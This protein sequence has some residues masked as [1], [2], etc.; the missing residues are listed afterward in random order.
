METE[1]FSKTVVFTYKSTRRNCPE[2]HDRHIHHVDRG[3]LNLWSPSEA[4]S[5][6]ADEEI[7]SLYGTQRSITMFKR[8]R[9]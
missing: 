9:R 5:H 6:Q 8:A 2:Y 7:P 3:I 1:C 4:S